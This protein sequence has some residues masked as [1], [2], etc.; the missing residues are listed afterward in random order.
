[1]KK[2]TIT[3]LLSFVIAN[4]FSQL[5]NKISSYLLAQYIH[6]THDVTLGNNPWGAGLDAIILYKNKTKFLPVI[7]LGAGIF[8]EDDKV[9]RLDTTSKMIE[10]IGFIGNAYIGVAIKPEKHVYVSFVAGP[11]F[12]NGQALLGIK[13]SVGFYFSKKQRCTAAFSFATIYNR[14]KPAS[15]DYKSV[16]IALGIRLF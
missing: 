8:L 12:I 9:A 15:D 16:N 4:C 7:D 3:L 11:A 2:T 13:P 1:L 6:T 5:H 14:Y 10:S